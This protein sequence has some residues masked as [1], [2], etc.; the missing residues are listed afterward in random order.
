MATLFGH[1]AFISL[2]KETTWGSAAT[3]NIDNRINSVQLQQNQERN[4]K[5]NLSV[6]ASGMLGEL[7][8]GFI[9]CEGTIEMPLYY[10]GQGLIFELAFGKITTTGSG[11]PY[12]HTF[13]PQITLPSATIGVQRGS[14]ISNQFEKFTGCKVTSLSVSAEAGGE[15]TASIDFIGKQALTRQANETA[16]FGTGA[17]ILHFH[18]GTLE[19]DSKSYNVRSMTYTITNNV[20]RRNVLGSKLTAEQAIGDVRTA[21]LDVTL[22]IENNDLNAAFLA[23][24]QSDVSLQFTSGSTS[25]KFMLTNAQISE[26]GDPVSG[27]GRVE[28]SMTFTGLA[29]SSN[30]GAKVILINADS[31]GIAN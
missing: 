21:T 28:Q 25:I 19:F 8:D 24:T 27:F 26:F 2:G 15:V 30:A 1:G 5:A 23:G 10:Q 11:A 18:A 12:T 16:S 13:E 7:F 6:P 4:Q 22:D 31:T 17:S 9:V 29:S 14:G 20:E 3:L